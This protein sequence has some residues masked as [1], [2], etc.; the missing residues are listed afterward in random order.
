MSA[1]GV[2]EFKNVASGRCLNINGAT[3][4]NYALMILY[5]CGSS[6]STNAEFS[7]Q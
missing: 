5:D 3:T 6:P 1:S 7:V 4:A 2:Y